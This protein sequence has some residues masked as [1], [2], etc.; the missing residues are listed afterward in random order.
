MQTLNIIHKGLR[1]NWKGKEIFVNERKHPA[2]KTKYFLWNLTD[3]CYLSSLFPT[4][5]TNIFYFDTRDSG[6]GYHLNIGTLKV[7]LVSDIGK[8]VG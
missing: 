1:F 6:K 8:K 4:E 2:G 7:K 5:K 3:K